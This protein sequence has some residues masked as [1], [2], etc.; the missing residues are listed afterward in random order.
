M[1]EDHFQADQALASA[2]KMLDAARS[3]AEV[4]TILRDTAR[5]IAGSDAIAVVLREGDC[6]HYVAEDAIGYLWQGNRFPLETCISGWA[7]LHNKTTIVPDIEV[8]PRLPADA[9]RHASMRSLVMVPIGLP[10][11]VAALGAYWCAFIE[12]DTGTVHRL[13]ALTESASRALAALSR[14]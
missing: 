2:R 11:P 4:V 10:E 3:L 12:V 14:H 13:E 1:S 8:D 5:Q 7:M 6:C 9:Y